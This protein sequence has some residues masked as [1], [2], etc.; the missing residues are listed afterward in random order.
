MLYGTTV[1]PT[2]MLEKRAQLDKEAV[3]PLLAA[4]PL[5]AKIGFGALTATGLW[6][7][8]KDIAKGNYASGAFNLATTLP[9]IGWAGSGLKAGGLL[10][11]IAARGGKF[12]NLAARWGSKPAVNALVKYSPEMAEAGGKMSTFAVGK[13]YAKRG[14]RHVGNKIGKGYEYLGRG[15]ASAPISQTSDWYKPISDQLMGASRLMNR[16]GVGVTGLGNRIGKTR[17]GNFMQSRR[18]IGLAIGGSMAMGGAG[19]PPSQAV[20]YAHPS[21]YAGNQA[22]EYAPQMFNQMPQGFQQQQPEYY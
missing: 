13:E 15:A 21:M 9:F 20:Q 22:M 10:A 17:Y 5:I 18:G 14:L 11:R 7:G 6:S 1:I 2:A 19:A 3:F 12:G 16:A 4:L 8:V